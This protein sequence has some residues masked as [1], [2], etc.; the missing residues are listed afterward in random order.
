M[1]FTA[2]IKLGSNLHNH[3]IGQNTGT[4]NIGKN[5]F[6]LIDG[7]FICD[8]VI[9]LPI[10]LASDDIETVGTNLDLKSLLSRIPPEYL[11]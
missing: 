9:D 7:I 10:L 4:L 3:W 6:D 2:K 5:R 11:D 8:D 1:F